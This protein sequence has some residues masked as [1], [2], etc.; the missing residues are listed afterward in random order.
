MSSCGVDPWIGNAAMPKLAVMFLSRKQRIGRNPAA[1][2]A[3]ELAGLLDTGFRH[4]D[5]ELVAA[6]ARHHVGAAAVLFEDVTHALEDDVALEV[7]VKIVHEF[8]AVEVHQHQRERAVR[9][10]RALPFGR[11]RFHEEA[12]CLDAGQAVGDGLFLRPLERER[13]VQRSGEEIGERAEQQ[14]VVIGELARLGR[15][16]VKDAEKLLAVGDG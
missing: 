8:E 10:R 1:E 2:L 12:M 14:H 3:G 6:V 11:E 7:A 13:V 9:A 15:F 4:E 16:D 5:H